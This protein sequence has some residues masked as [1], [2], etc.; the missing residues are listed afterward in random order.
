MFKVQSIAFLPDPRLCFLNP[1]K[2]QLEIKAFPGSHALA[3]VSCLFFSV[4]KEALPQEQVD[5][6]S[7]LFSL[8]QTI[9]INHRKGSVC[10]IVL[11]LWI[12]LHIF[13]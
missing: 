5:C 13:L 6:W 3:S 10:L 7:F 9:H 8:P 12:P 2:F 11:L 1:Q 4:A